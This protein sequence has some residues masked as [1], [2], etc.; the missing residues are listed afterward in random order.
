[1]DRSMT[2]T[3]FNWTDSSATGASVKNVVLVQARREALVRAAIDVFCDK[4]YHLSRII[5]I[6]N[7]A[8]VS[9]GTIYNYVSCKED[10]LYLICED[11]FRGYE[12]IVAAA[13]EKATS[14]R[15]RLDALLRATIDVI[16][17]YRKHYVVMLREL[18]HV[19][20]TKRRA[21]FSLAAEQRKLVQGVLKDVAKHK[22]ILIDDPLVTANIL[23]YLPKLVVSRGWDLKGKVDDEAV[24][25]MLLAF[26]QRGLGLKPQQQR[27]R[28]RSHRRVI[29]KYHKIPSRSDHHL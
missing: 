6:A 12:Q 3:P 10:L 27:T 16:F 1:M 28:K 26:M 13:L 24:A 17:K 4:G 19:N 11:H 22:P 5:D 7:A 20:S 25:Q 29:G 8:G 23:V 2:L 14:P 15:E 21:F 9:H 18:H